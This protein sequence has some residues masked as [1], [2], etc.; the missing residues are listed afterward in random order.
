[1]KVRAKYQI[2][3]KSILYTCGQTFE[4]DEKDYEKYK[5][6]VEIVEDKFPFLRVKTKPIDNLKNKPKKGI[7]TK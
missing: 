7:K 6:D 1:M 5:N 3:Y 4:I 2:G